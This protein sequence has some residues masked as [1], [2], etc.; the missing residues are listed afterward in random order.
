MKIM[1]HQGMMDIATA[2]KEYQQ[3]RRPDVE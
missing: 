2:L 3:H 1:T